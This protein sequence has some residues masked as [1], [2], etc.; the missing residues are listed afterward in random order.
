MNTQPIQQ[1]YASLPQAGAFVSLL[2]DAAVGRVFLRGLVDSA[3]PAFFASVVSK[4]NRTVVFVLNVADEASYF[5]H[6]LIQMMGTASAFFLPS[7]YCR[8][9]KFAQR[10]AANQILRT[11][12]LLR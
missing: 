5:Y 9:V 6:D 11:V 7:S 2:E 1:L 10:D 12:V 8:A 3:T 4:I